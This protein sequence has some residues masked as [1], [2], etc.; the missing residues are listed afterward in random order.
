MELQIHGIPSCL[1]IER[2]QK[3]D[4]NN[5]IKLRNSICKKNLNLKQKILLKLPSN[6]LILLRKIQIILL[7]VN[8]Y[9]TPFK[10]YPKIRL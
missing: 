5:Y 4:I 2:K 9:I 7:K 8:I 10:Y 3:G 6:I 1:A